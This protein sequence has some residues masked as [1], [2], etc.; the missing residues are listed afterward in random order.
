MSEHSSQIN[1]RAYRGKP[2]SE[3]QELSNKAKSRVCVRVKHVFGHMH[4][5]MAGR[6]DTD[7]AQPKLKPNAK[8]VCLVATFA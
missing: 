1:A 3:A 8:S 6:V 5:S 2:L 7:Q 4:N